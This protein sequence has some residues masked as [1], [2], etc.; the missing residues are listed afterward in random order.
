MGPSAKDPSATVS[1][2]RKR[3]N[4]LMSSITLVLSDES[5]VPY[6]QPECSKGELVTR[7]LVY[8]NLLTLSPDHFNDPEGY[9]VVWERCCRN[10]SITNIFSGNPQ[11]GQTAAGQTFY[12]EFPPVVKNGAPFHNSSPR[13]FPPLSDFACPSKPYYVDFAGIDD[14]G[15]SLVYSITTPLNTTTSDALPPVSPGPFPPVIWK[16]G[17]SLTNIING[18]PDLRISKEGL[19]TATPRTLGLFVFAVKVDEYRAGEKIGE[20]RRDFQM[21]VD[22]LCPQSE[23]PVITGKNLPMSTLHFP[24]ICLFRSIMLL[25]M[26]IGASMFA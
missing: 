10:Y 15:D 12:L 26:Q 20:S 17:F 6:T 8:T 9:F 5:N 3:D 2:F 4:V 21:L 14:D 24:I 19:L 13:L 25:Q 7:K 1:I 16:S 22:D 11:L 18:F 23:P